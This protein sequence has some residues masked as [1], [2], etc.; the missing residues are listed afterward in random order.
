VP[1]PTTFDSRADFQQLGFRVPAIVA[2]PTVKRGCPVSTV[3][4]HVSV[5]STATRLLGLDAIN[6]RV[7]QTTDFRDCINPDYI[8]NPQPG[9]ELPPVEISM[10]ALRALPELA[11]HI[12]L[13]KAIAPMNLPSRLNRKSESLAI[14]ER[15]LRYGEGL[16][17][18]KLTR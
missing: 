7:T 18:V 14:A 13:A 2:G 9:A 6:E 15:V 4:D 11:R 3:Y 12:E 5:A 17:A 1:P 10:S 8:G 16:G